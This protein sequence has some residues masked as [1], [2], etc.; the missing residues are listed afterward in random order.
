MCYITICIVIELKIAAGI[1]VGIINI[2]L[3]LYIILLD[4]PI[5]TDGDVVNITEGL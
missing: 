1:K 5:N 3:V 2:A 4:Y